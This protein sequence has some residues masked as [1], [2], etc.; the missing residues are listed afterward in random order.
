M[1]DWQSIKIGEYLV[2]YKFTK[3]VISSDHICP[4]CQSKIIESNEIMM[5]VTNG[6]FPNKL[7]HERC[8]NGPVRTIRNLNQDYQKALKYQHWFS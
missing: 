7:V 8:V 3:S 1:S 5:I 2:K 6:C 4:I